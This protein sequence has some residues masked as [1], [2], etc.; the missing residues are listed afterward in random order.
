MYIEEKKENVTLFS[1]FAFPSSH[2]I[3]DNNKKKTHSKF[4]VALPKNL[5][6]QTKNREKLKQ[7]FFFFA[8]L[9]K[10]THNISGS[11]TVH[12]SFTLISLNKP[13][14]RRDRADFFSCLSSTTFSTSFVYTRRKSRRKKGE[15]NVC[16]AV[17]RVQTK[18][19][20]STV[21]ATFCCFLFVLCI[22]PISSFLI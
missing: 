9:S 2:Q 12:I 5:L 18:Q 1:I 17:E 22:R 10:I 20:T 11:V 4:M 21:I 16:S 19:K 13:Q 3:V 15:T 6:S 14:E 7:I 8:V